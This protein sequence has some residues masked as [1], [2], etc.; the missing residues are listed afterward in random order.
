M[1]RGWAKQENGATLGFDARLWVAADGL[2]GRKEA[3]EY[4]VIST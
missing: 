4:E 1:A 2:R 3:A